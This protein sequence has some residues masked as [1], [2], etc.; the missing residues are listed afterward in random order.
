[1]HKY[2]GIKTEKICIKVV[3]QFTNWLLLYGCFALQD[4]VKLT[5]SE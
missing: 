3:R 1:M 2:T 4:F 5:F